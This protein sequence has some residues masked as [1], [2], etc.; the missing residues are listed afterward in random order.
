MHSAAVVS[1]EMSSCMKQDTGEGVLSKEA[2][3]GHT[4][5]YCSSLRGKVTQ[6]APEDV[7]I[8]ARA[9]GNSQLVAEVAE[10]QR[11]Q[12]WANARRCLCQH[13]AEARHKI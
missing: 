1:A 8:E 6:D 10:V 12:R 5:L 7:L 3:T 2:G 4:E 13:P 11:R 9:E